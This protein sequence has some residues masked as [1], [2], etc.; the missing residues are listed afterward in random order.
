MVRSEVD[1]GHIRSMT[2][3]FLFVKLSFFPPVH[4]FSGCS[5]SEERLETEVD[6][7]DDEVVR[8]F[9]ESPPRDEDDTEGGLKS[10][11]GVIMGK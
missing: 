6:D 11:C 7:T 2:M 1:G 3:S 4:R 8:P 10:V 9:T 5:S